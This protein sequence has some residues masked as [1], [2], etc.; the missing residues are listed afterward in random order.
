M[1]LI[2]YITQ[3]QIDFGAV[4]LL[5]QECDRL[6]IRRPLV[7]TDAGVRAAGVL[8]RVTAQLGAGREFVV[9]DG[10]PSNPTERAMRAAVALYA[11]H[12]C[13]GIVAVGG[14]SP[15]DLAKGVAVCATHEGPLKSF[16]AIEG[17]V[18]RITAATAPVIA[19]PTTAGTG[20]EVGRGAVLILDDGRKVGVLSPHLV[21]RV[22]LCDPELTLGLPPVLTAATGM[23][24]IAHCMETFMAPAFNPPADGIALDGL[25][26]AW[27]HIERATATPG[28]RAARL[29][30]MSA[31]MQGALAFQKGLG[32]VHSLSHSLG[33]IAPR[34]HHGT[35]NA[36]LLPAVIR[37]NAQAESMRKDERLARMAQA[38][39]LGSG[40][41][42]AP[43]V[44]AMSAR[45]GLPTGLAALDV[46]PD[47]FPR[48]IEGALKDHCHKTN[49]REASVADYQALLA[50]SM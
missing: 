5:A 17:G 10:T 29:N 41:E 37:F 42:V 9:F 45:L 30:M 36:I 43:A 15:I 11:E 4:Q 48:V 34:L 16:A 33:G 35:L 28:D 47:L 24:A 31:S 19:V 2:H 20:S 12:R 49:P 1:A 26:R 40:D 25:R 38:M 18:A 50:E 23:D 44:A 46:A 8:E 32:C 14:G 3:I 21:P 22:A 13:D 39:G 6:G 7:V 27:R